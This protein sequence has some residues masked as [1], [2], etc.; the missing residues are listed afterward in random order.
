MKLLQD[1]K[2]IF[3]FIK[4]CW[5]CFS[6]SQYSSCFQIVVH[7]IKSADRSLMQ[8]LPNQ[9]QR[10]LFYLV[11]F[12]ISM[13]CR[14]TYVF[15]GACIP[16]SRCIW[17]SEIDFPC[18]TV[19]IILRHDLSLNLKLIIVLARLSCP[20]RTV[21]LNSSYTSLSLYMPSQL[22]LT[23]VFCVQ[24]QHREYFIVVSTTEFETVIVE[25]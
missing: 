1:C 12:L 21:T 11:L 25:I 17:R 15:V 6:Y 8:N 3:Y 16:L 14:H 23:W 9:L 24:S 20:A 4:S 18:P 5:D 10:F 7:F 19:L 2:V 22:E 13:C